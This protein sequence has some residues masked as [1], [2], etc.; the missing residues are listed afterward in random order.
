MNNQKN[1]FIIC[2]V[3]LFFV[4][5]DQVTG[6][7]KPKKTINKWNMS[8]SLSSVYD[9]NVL[10]NSEK[11][12]Q[13]FRDNE[14]EGRF[15]INRYDDLIMQYEA[16]IS[17]S[18]KIFGKRSSIFSVSAD[19]N[20]FSYNSVKTWSNLSI[21]LQQFISAPTSFNISYSYLPDYY[22]KHYRDFDWINVLGYTPETF[23]PMSFS[24]NDFSFWLQH[25]FISATRAR[26]YFSYMKYYYNQHFTEYDSDNLLYGLR[27]FHSFNKN[28]TA[29]AGYR[30]ITSDAK[31][32]DSP[33]ET[34]IISDDGDASY[35]EHTY[36]AGVEIQLPKA[37][38]LKNNLGLSA[39]YSL[40]NYTTHKTGEEDRVH[41]GRFDNYYS[42]TIAYNIAVVKNI[43]L[44]AF[45][46]RVSR[47]S[48]TDISANSEYLSDEKDY[49]QNLLGLSFQYKFNF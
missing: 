46:R 44:S 33:G 32:Y 26:I 43:S 15:H 25:N 16:R 29:D 7:G 30:Y 31:G 2:A 38:N 1:I 42:F 13:R 35:N 34:K 9:N 8:L 19:H 22:I 37:F 20:S 41:S 24:K 17:Y 10:R 5:A 23:K 3:L 18:E 36:Y 21:G 40:R 47:N 14:D 39:Q 4:S 11:Y 27:L 49:S 6:S 28:I 45:F 48:D 12:L